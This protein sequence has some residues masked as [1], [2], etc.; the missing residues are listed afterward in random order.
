MGRML[1]YDDVNECLLELGKAE[2]IVA[3]K[4][5]EMNTQ[6]QKIKEKYDKE[7]EEQ[8]LLAADL[9]KKIESFC[10]ANKGDFTKQRSNMMTHGV[11]G[12]RNNPPKVVQLSKKWSVKSSLEFLKKLFNAKYVRS[13]DEMNKDQILA[14]YAA[15]IVTD[16]S[17]A[18]AGIRIE[19]DETFFIEINWDTIQ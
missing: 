18:A 13:K 9:E 15:G 19:N 10:N 14:D 1:S 8:R 6:I 17:L 3:R 12:F 5:A 7:T 2:S 16:S 11:V 4:E